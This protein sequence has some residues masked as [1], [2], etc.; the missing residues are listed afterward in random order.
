MMDYSLL[1]EQKI[2]EKYNGLP[3]DLKNVLSSTNTSVT[4]ENIG[5][6]YHLENEKNLMLTQLVGLVI[7]GFVNFEE[8]KEEMRETIDISPQFIPLIA[9]EIRQKIF[10]PVTKLMPPVQILKPTPVAPAAPAAPITMSTPTPRPVTPTAPRP[11]DQYREPVIGPEVINL[12]NQPTQTPQPKPNIPA[13]AQPLQPKPSAPERP[14]IP[15][16]A[17]PPKPV[18]ATPLIEADPH[19]TPIATMPQVIIRPSGLPPTEPPYDVLNLRKDK[20]EF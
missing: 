1:T 9:D 14:V 8:M 3:Q 6:K 11:V 2:L 7:L 5:S 17:M 20:G 18:P 10:A 12:R 15:P 19:K 16:P 4:I 13:S